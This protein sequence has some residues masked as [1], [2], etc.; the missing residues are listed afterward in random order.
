MTAKVKPRKPELVQADIEHLLAIEPDDR[1]LRAKLEELT[2]EQGFHGVASYVWAPRLYQRNRLLFRPFIRSH[3]APYTFFR[4]WKWIAWKGE[5]ARALEP[6]LAEVD[7]HGDIPL[8]HTL[9]AWKLGLGGGSPFRTIAS[10]WRRDLLARFRAAGT[11]HERR[12]VLQRFDLGAVRLDEEAALEIYG[13]ERAVT[14]PFILRHLP[15]SGWSGGAKRK[16]WAQLHAAAERS[17][18]GRFALDLYRRQI[19]VS[20]WREDVKRLCREVGSA[21]GLVE[22]LEKRHPHGW[23]SGTGHALRDVLEARGREVFPYV[24]RHLRDVWRSALGRESYH[25][26]LDLALRRGWHDLRA[27]VIRT[28][29]TAREFN[30]A[31][32]DIL[33]AP[34]SDDE[35]VGRLAGLAGVARE[36]NLGGLGLA[37]AH[38]LDDSTAAVLYGR[39]PA[40]LRRLFKAHVGAR[41][42]EDYEELIA[43]SRQ[44]GDLELVDYLAS[45]ALMQVDDKEQLARAESLSA[46]YEALLD[47]P[48]EFARRAAAV[49]TQVP[50][51][52]MSRQYGL[53]IKKNRLARLLYER[54]APTYLADAAG[55]RDL[56]EAPEIHVQALALRALG[57][58]DPR[59]EALA[60]ANVDLLQATLLRP[61]HRRTR[62]LAFAALLNAA[63]DLAAAR[64]VLEKARQALD[65][66][67]EHYDKEALVGLI[68][69]ILHRW[70]DLRGVREHPPVRRSVPVE[71]VS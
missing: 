68:G 34:I 11:A 1:V 58:S 69:R 41:W 29:G 6:W 52:S 2:K 51:F 3:L 59:A 57:V 26:I 17:G 33:A 27:E 18:D 42:G 28:C 19:P 13:L 38:A 65:L 56:L 66:P 70:P 25:E 39:F 14:P 35:T 62:R 5:A 63:S 44:A 43:R 8:F 24:L 45:R 53:A 7:R 54:A 4:R 64:G 60:R 40:L 30:E 47:R 55:I 48:A 22:E 31:V 10:T 21:E 49:L 67:D 46:E 16:L 23:V 50:A 9:Y 15:M 20:V 37:Q 36:L 71:A 61:L 32:R 12:E